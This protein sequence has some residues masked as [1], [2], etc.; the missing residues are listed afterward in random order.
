MRG[1][2]GGCADTSYDCY[3]FVGRPNE[4]DGSTTIY[5]NTS[6]WELSQNHYETQLST[7]TDSC[8]AI[9]DCGWGTFATT[10]GLD[11]YCTNTDDWTSTV[12]T[13]DD[14]IYLY[15]P[16]FCKKGYELILASNADTTCYPFNEQVSVYSCAQ[17]QLG[18]FCFLFHC[19]TDD[20]FMNF[21]INIDRLDQVIT[22]Y[23]KMIQSME[24][25]H[26]CC[27]AQGPTPA[28][29]RLTNA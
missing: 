7:T 14:T 8:K 19:N 4:D 18:M 2:A 20:Q 13:G 5:S 9:L 12:S 21:D 29:L 1:G 15:T 24:I 11:D 6:G 10:N 22:K 3:N 23:M 28:S 16:Q 17:C 26:A 27:A 25:R